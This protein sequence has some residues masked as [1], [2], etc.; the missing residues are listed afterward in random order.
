MVE[1]YEAAKDW[2]VALTGLHRDAWHLYF[3]LVIQLG[4]AQLFQRRLASPFPLLVVFAF[5][6]FNECLD[7]RL[8][9]LPGADPL[10]GLLQDTIR[11]AI[12]TIAPPTL[13]FLL[14]RFH[15]GRLIGTT[16]PA[17]A[18]EPDQVGPA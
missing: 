2:L 6:L 9:H 10:K 13:L 17:E 5:E 16:R 12:N 11:D 14:A 4:A 15:A 8:Y 3:A 18:T 1:S 7:Y